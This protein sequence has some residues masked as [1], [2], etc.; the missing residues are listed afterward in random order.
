MKVL[1]QRVSRAE[2][3]VE[4]RTVGAIGRGALVFL[5]VERGDAEQ[6]ARWYARRLS[7][8][9]LFSDPAQG[10]WRRTLAEVDGAA[11]VVSQFTLPARTRKGRRPSFDD[12]APP[13]RARILYEL[14]IETLRGEGLPVEEGAFGEMMQVELVN[15]GPVTF[16]LDGPS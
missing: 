14:F 5:G 10:P 16:L 6:Q 11:L 1:L 3:R 12:A 9:K 2:V 8:L 13:E 7:L 15:D 4:G